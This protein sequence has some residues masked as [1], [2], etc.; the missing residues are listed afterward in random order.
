MRAKTERTGNVCISGKEQQR[1]GRRSFEAE[2][3][4]LTR[5]RYI[6]VVHFEGDSENA[7][8]RRKEHKRRRW[9][10]GAAQRRNVLT[11]AEYVLCG[12]CC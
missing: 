9:G 12:R 10:A 5:N 8:D 2:N 6:C 4:R 11:P 3:E 1:R 7:T